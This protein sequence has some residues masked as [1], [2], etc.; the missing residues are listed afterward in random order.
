MNCCIY[1]LQS[2][3]KLFP[4]AQCV[5]SLDVY[6]YCCTENS[7]NCMVLKIITCTKLDM[8]QKFL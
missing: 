6:T 2:I 5:I 4:L 1:D 3:S 8:D 7:K